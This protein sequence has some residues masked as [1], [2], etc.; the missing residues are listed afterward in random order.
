[1][2]GRE[3]KA[4]SGKL[5]EDVDLVRRPRMGISGQ[6]SAGVILAQIRAM[7]FNYNRQRKE[8]LHNKGRIK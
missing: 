6:A 2:H 3:S 4:D 5:Y 8:M 1:M 7:C